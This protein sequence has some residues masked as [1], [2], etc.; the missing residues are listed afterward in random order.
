MAAGRAIALAIAVAMLRPVWNQETQPPLLSSEN[1]PPARDEDSFDPTRPGRLRTG[2][3]TTARVTPC[4]SGRA[5]TR[6]RPRTRTRPVASGPTLPP[7]SSSISL[8]PAMP[9]RSAFSLQPWKPSR[10]S[11]RSALPRRDPDERRHP[12]RRLPAIVANPADR[13]DVWMVYVSYSGRRR[14]AAGASTRRRGPGVR[15]TRSWSDRRR[16]ASVAR[17][18]RQ[19]QAVGD[20]TAGAVRRRVRPLRALVRRR[21]MGDDSSA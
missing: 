14:A 11:S 20:G 12:R 15:G 2:S 10:P 4:S 19:G 16:L 1:A 9:E 7:G 3:S 18:R 17:V 5:A 21:A 13:D 6:D 8:D